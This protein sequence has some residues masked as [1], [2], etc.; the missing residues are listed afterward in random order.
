MDTDTDK[1]MK[2]QI[3][4]VPSEQVG[5]RVDI[6]I[7]THAPDHLSR[8]AVQSLIRQGCVTINE[9][10]PK[11]TSVKISQGDV[12]KFQMPE[13]QDTHIVAESIPLNILHEDSDIIVIDKPAG[14]VVHP[15]PGNWSG[16]LVNALL[17]HCKG[18]LSG[19]GG[20]RRPGIVHRLD[21]DTGGV[22]VVAKSYR[23]HLDLQDQF[24][25]H[26]RTGHLQRIYQAIVWGVPPR[27]KGTI[28]APLGRHPHDR[29]KRAVVPDSRNDAKPALTHYEVIKT[30]DD[31][32]SLIECRLQT[33]RTHQIRVHLSHID[34]PLLGD[35]TYGSHYA[36]KAA[37]LNDDARHA[38]D[39]LSRQ[40]LHAHCLEF[41]H[42]TVGDILR[43]NSPLPKD[44]DDLLQALNH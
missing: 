11:G 27:M 44:M 32:V 35:K 42:P 6:F 19:I 26:G 33:G 43:F 9:K 41:R 2:E 23:A 5:K 36:T 13:A 24:A 7:S 29:L 12:I 18:E 34:H 37:H 15:A 30:F 40:A 31:T 14:M 16:T 4:I 25:D 22:L 39:I 8:A 3:L 28:D 38:L 21:K 10:I 17:H 20:V 1:I